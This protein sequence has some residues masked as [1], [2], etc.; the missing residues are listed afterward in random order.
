MTKAGDKG[1]RRLWTAEFITV[2]EL[3]I[4][5]A[6]PAHSAGIGDIK[7]ATGR[8]MSGSIHHCVGM[9]VTNDERIRH[10]FRAAVRVDEARGSEGARMRT[11][12]KSPAT[13]RIP[14]ITGSRRTA[15]FPMM[16]SGTPA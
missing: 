4:M 8:T 6:A 11:P 2:T 12:A 10:E 3:W 9:Q 5:A 16:F 1:E 15:I 14:T 7:S 13:G